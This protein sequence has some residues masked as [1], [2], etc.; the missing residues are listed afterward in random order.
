MQLQQWTWHHYGHYK[1]VVTRLTSWRKSR[2]SHTYQPSRGW[3]AEL[4]HRHRAPLVD[5]TI[6]PH[7]HCIGLCRLTKVWDSPNLTFF[8]HEI[9]EVVLKIQFQNSTVKLVF[10]TWRESAPHRDVRLQISSHRLHLLCATTRGFC[11]IKLSFQFKMTEIRE[12]QANSGT[13]LINRRRMSYQEWLLWLQP[14][15]LWR[16]DNCKDEMR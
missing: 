5:S 8:K 16:K 11:S 9:Y 3:R 10:W 7:W 1:C 12:S 6:F 13:I 4:I 14:P 15:L 2:S